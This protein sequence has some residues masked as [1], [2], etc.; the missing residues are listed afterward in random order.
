M[1]RSDVTLLLLLRVSDKLDR[2][3]PIVRREENRIMKIQD[4][5]DGAGV[6]LDQLGTDD[7]ALLAAVT[8]IENNGGTLT[9]TQ[10]AA[11]QD[12]LN[13][14]DAIDAADVAALAALQPAPPADGGDTP[15]VDGVPVDGAPVDG[16]VSQ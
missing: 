16:S 12:A 13:R 3:L 9:D 4:L 5:L 11:A 15:P 6:K 7:A 14:I 10:A 8:D 2:L 1:D